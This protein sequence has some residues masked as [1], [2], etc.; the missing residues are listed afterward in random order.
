MADIAIAR[1][2]TCNSLFEAFPSNK[3]Y[4][5]GK[6]Q[7]RATKRRERAASRQKRDLMRELPIDIRRHMAVRLLTSLALPIPVE[8]LKPSTQGET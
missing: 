3:R 1:C 4:C 2:P 7:R 5:S 6:C 8:L